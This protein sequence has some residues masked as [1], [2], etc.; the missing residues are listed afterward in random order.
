MQFGI[1]VIPRRKAAVTAEEVEDEENSQAVSSARSSTANVVAKLMGLDVV[2][3]GYDGRSPR[4]YSDADDKA[5]KHHYY[6]KTK[7]KMTSQTPPPRHP[8]QSRNSNVMMACDD[9]RRGTRSLPETPRI[10]FA[11]R[12]GDSDP[13]L[14]IQS[15]SCINKENVNLNVRG[16]LS[17]SAMQELKTAFLDYSSSS[18]SPSL[19]LPTKAEKEEFD[20]RKKARHM[21]GEQT[22]SPSRYAKEIVRQ[23]KDS[24]VSRRIEKGR[25]T[26][27]RQN[28]TPPSTLC[29]PRAIQVPEVSERKPTP[30]TSKNQTT[31]KPKP[32]PK[33]K[34]VSSDRFN[35]RLK[36]PPV[37]SSTNNSS[38]IP[39]ISSSVSPPRPPKRSTGKIKINTP[40]PPLPNIAVKKD[41]KPAT[42]SNRPKATP[43]PEE[44]QYLKRVLEKAG[45]RCQTSHPVSVRWNSPYHPLDPIIFHQLELTFTWSHIPKGQLRHRCNR[46]HLFELIDELLADILY[47]YYGLQRP[48]TAAYNNIHNM[49]GEALLNQIWSKIRSFPA[50]KCEVIQDID[51]LV[52]WDLPDP[53]IRNLLNHPAV[54]EETYNITAE[55]ERSISKL[56]LENIT[57]T[58]LSTHLTTCFR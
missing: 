37:V 7:E 57:D 5:L 16:N 44:L 46:K 28:Q 54:E 24:V 40:S 53:N 48:Q 36:K 30:S 20:C 1:Q 49:E 51:A 56:L 33:C 17:A 58:M 45:I 55:I 27:S 13:R 34:K 21:V 50:A 9:A 31:P 47:P 3:N 22:N 52:E 12:S 32:S 39:S 43:V 23:M 41:N 4:T 15:N 19:V 6:R 18:Y 2:S 26:A 10:T 38:F 42:H 14:S 29:S 25:S 35:E 11:R 8:L